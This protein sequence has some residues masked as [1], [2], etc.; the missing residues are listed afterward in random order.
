ME[1]IIGLTGPSGVGK[2]FV[3][4]AI[5]T[6]FPG[7]LIE[8]IVVTTRPKRSDDGPDRLAGISEEEFELM[9]NRNEIIFAHTPFGNNYKYGFMR[10]SFR[11]GAPALTEVH[12]DNV[13]R[14][15]DEFRSSLYLIGI[16]ASRK[17]LERNL[18][19]RGTNP[20]DIDVRLSAAQTEIKK[21]RSLH[22]TGQINELVSVGFRNRDRFVNELI[23]LVEN[24][25]G[26]DRI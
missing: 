17:Y 7:R 9:T 24:Q 20:N 19:D 12:V 16:F 2:G 10:S 11:T 23:H 6:A 18:S 8:P 26:T 22:S 5:L 21:I 15:K 14:F 4:K 13:I 3:K 1:Q 25:I